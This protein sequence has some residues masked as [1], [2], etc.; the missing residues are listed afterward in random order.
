MKNQILETA[1]NLLSLEYVYTN[2]D[3]R[4]P[5]ITDLSDP[6]QFE[7]VYNS[8]DCRGSVTF[9]CGSGSPDPYL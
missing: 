9:W 6:E 4:D 2:P 3:P 8:V 1:G 5:L 7:Y